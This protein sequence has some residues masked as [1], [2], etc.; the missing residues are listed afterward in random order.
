MNRLTKRNEIGQAFYPYCFRDDTCGGIGCSE[1]CDKCEHAEMTCERLAD[2]EDMQEALEKRIEEIKSS[3][4]YPH[5]FTGQ[6]VEDFEWV[7]KM[8]RKEEKDW[9]FDP[10]KVNAELGARWR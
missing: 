4:E 7:L 10:M 6:M 1:N 2:Y 5:N 3:S 8:L 9:H